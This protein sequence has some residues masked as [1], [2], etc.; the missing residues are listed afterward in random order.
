MRFDDRWRAAVKAE[1]DATEREFEITRWYSPE[2]VVGA[3]IYNHEVGYWLPI[4]RSYTNNYSTM[5][6]TEQ[7]LRLCRAIRVEYKT[8]EGFGRS[9]SHDDVFIVEDSNKVRMV[10]DADSF[11]IGKPD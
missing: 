4:D 5:H 7:E 11:S 1:L 2:P 3:S 6:M 9:D 8:D 10:V